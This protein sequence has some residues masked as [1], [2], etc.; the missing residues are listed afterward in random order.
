[1]SV[2]INFNRPLE[3]LLVED[4]PTDAQLTREA[5]AACDTKINV[6]HVSDGIAAME[7][8]ERVA[9]YQDAPRPDLIFLDLKMPRKDGCEVLQEVKRSED[10]KMIPVI[11]L[12]T[13]VAEADITRAFS[14]AANSYVAKPLDFGQ[15]VEVIKIIEQFWFKV[16]S[17]PS[18]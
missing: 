11:V 12:T 8:L 4:S 5:L 16:A 18:H 9:P 3:I 15:F 10:L 1:M 6:H 13:S 14:H 7:F 17:L 2:A